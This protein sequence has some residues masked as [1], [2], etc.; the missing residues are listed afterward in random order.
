[1]LPFLSLLLSISN[2]WLL[3]FSLFAGGTVNH[4]WAC[5]LNERTTTTAWCARVR[6]GTARG[7]RLCRSWRRHRVVWR[8][9]VIHRRRARRAVVTAI[10]ASATSCR[11]TAAAP[12]RGQRGGRAQAQKA[13]ERGGHYCRCWCVESR[14]NGRFD[15]A[16][17]RP[18]ALRLTR[19]NT[20]LIVGSRKS[21]NINNILKNRDRFRI[22]VGQLENLLRLVQRQWDERRHLTCGQTRHSWR[23]W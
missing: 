9:T 14:W 4:H 5:G 13:A 3:C 2:E 8:E 16:F 1:M 19:G 21:S 11:G 22:F 17:A 6:R 10:P 12:R 15:E 20:L 23:K 7:R 18:A